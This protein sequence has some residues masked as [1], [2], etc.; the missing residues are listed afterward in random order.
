M[1]LCKVSCTIDP[2]VLPASE[3]CPDGVPSY[4]VHNTYTRQ[5]GPVQTQQFVV[6]T[7]STEYC[8]CYGQACVYEWNPNGASFSVSACF[9]I[10]LRNSTY[11]VLTVTSSSGDITVGMLGSTGDA[12]LCTAANACPPCC[13]Y[14]G[15]PSSKKW[16]VIGY[17]H[18]V[19][20]QTITGACGSVQY[21][22]DG[23]G[24]APAAWYS[25][26]TLV[27]CIEIGRAHV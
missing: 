6:G 15:I 14:V 25:S 7:T 9:R 24:F 20:P 27:Y 13:N 23:G 10:D 16:V 2:C 18:R 19:A 1:K 4:G 8:R 12:P 11:P 21:R 26:Y 3:T 5:L 22:N 17:Q